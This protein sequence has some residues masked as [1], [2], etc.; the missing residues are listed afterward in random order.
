[1]NTACPLCRS[2]RTFVLQSTEPLTESDPMLRTKIVSAGDVLSFVACQ[3]CGLLFRA[4]RPTPE[5]LTEFYQH[6]G[7]SQE[8]GVMS[9]LGISRELA[10]TRNDVRYAR[11]FDELRDVVKGAPGHIIDIGGGDGRSL[12]P[13]HAAGWSTTLIDPGAASRAL[14]SPDMRSF[15]SVEEAASSG[16]QPATLITSYHCIEH[17]L[18][19]DEWIAESRLLSDAKTVWVIEVPFEVIY[20]R[21]LL[22]KRRLE[23]ANV[24][25]MHLNF[26]TPRSLAA[27][28]PRANVT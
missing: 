22:R 21:K 9:A 24:H 16:L 19:I 5:Q 14:A 2:D 28:A 6:T 10:D 17:L 12:M 3:A 11:L 1:M 18:H 25:D 26:F 15:C 23:R 7:P 20:I 27:L 4:P 13:W 8:L